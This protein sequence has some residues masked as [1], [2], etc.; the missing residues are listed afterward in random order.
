MSQNSNHYLINKKH[1]HFIG[2]GGSGMYP[3]V[4]ILHN[5]GFFITGSD[6]NDTETIDAL[7]KIGIKV[8]L[9]QNANNIKNS[10]L[11]VYT[12]AISEDNLELIAAKES[13]IDII[14]RSTLL[15][16]LSE[17]KNNA[18]C[19]SGTHGKTTVSSMIS[20]IMIDCKLDPTCII[21]G[22]LKNLNG[23]GKLGESEN[24]VIEACEF[25]DAFLKLHPDIAVILNID[26]DHLDYFK[27]LENIIKSFRRF[28]ENATKFIVINGDDQNCNKCIENINKKVITFGLNEDCDYYAKAITKN[29]NNFL[30]EYDLYNEGNFVMHISLNVPGEHNVLN[31]LAALATTLQFTENKTAIYNTL[32]NFKGA[33]RRFQI[34][35]KI[36]GV[37]I[38]D[39]YGHHP[40][41]IKTT[42]EAAKSM[43]YNKIWVIHQPFTFSRTSIFIKEFA[44]VLQIADNVLLTD[45]MGGREKN[46]FNIKIEDL[47]ALI[48]NCLIIKD[49]KEMADYVMS[50][51]K[52]GDLILTTG[53]GDVNKIS[54][55]I[56]KRY[57]F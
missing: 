25:K 54:N 20:S 24:M 50:K 53:C 2:I 5:Q 31:S 46:T 23:S 12:T 13:N 36:N 27:N 33:D 7:R 29:T 42:L 56:V 17:Q 57:K 44:N 40:V 39:D 21:G 52:E 19:I 37:T 30:Y 35:G 47:S 22:K 18:I 15:S 16:I 10:D 41:E 26:E 45:I 51:A 8:T 1:I 4:Q 3:L 28:S 32:K 14:E 55:D 11:I 6:N 38:A 43:N 48:D 9:I 34:L 49:F